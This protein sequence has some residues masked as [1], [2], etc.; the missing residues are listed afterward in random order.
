MILRIA[1]ILIF[2]F[3]GDAFAQRR[4]DRVRSMFG[5]R[6]YADDP[7]EYG[8]GR[9][10][11]PMWEVE[12]ETPKDCFMF[13]R[14]K[15]RSWTQQ[16][17]WNWYTD[18]RDSDL[19]LSF[20][21]HQLTAMKVDPEGTYVEI[22]DPRL[23][24]YPFLFMTGVGGLELDEKEAAILR[25]YMLNG[26]FIMVDDFHGHQQWDNF[27][28]CMKMVF[29]DREPE[30][31][32]LEH[33]VF[34]LVYDLKEKFQ[35]PNIGIARRFG[36]QRTWEEADWK[37]IHYCAFYDDHK[38]M[39]CFI[40]HNTDL[41]DGWEEENK[42]PFYFEVFSEPKAYPIGFNVIVYAMTH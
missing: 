35:I 41:G 10:S 8:E 1:F 36:G 4:M 2:L 14:I 21:L 5:G 27:Y 7:F 9:K 39:C 11:V 33:P 18:Y 12:P 32:P 29:P 13:A 40:G 38:R 17:S 42:D 22:T 19:N 37:E 16:R 24:D 34:H 6:G 28:N 20:R 30:D 31:I 3:A 15:Y 26:G 25:R 23:F